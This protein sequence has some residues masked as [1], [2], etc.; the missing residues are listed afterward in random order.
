MRTIK[1][2]AFV[3]M[4]ASALAL[5]GCGG[6]GSSSSMVAPTATPTTPT[7]EPTTPPAPTSTAVMLPALPE[8]DMYLLDTADFPLEIAA[9]GMDTSGGVEFSCPAG[10]EDCTVTLDEDGMATSEGGAATAGLTKVA[11]D[12]LAMQKMAA[13]TEL[14]GRAAGLHEAL[15]RSGGANDVF[16]GGPSGNPVTV[17]P[18]RIP[19]AGWTAG[20]N[21]DVVITRGLTGDLM[22]TRDRAGWHGDAMAAA[23]AGATGWAGR[24]LS[25]GATQ[26][27]TVYS[28][29]A[30]AMRADFEADVASSIYRPGLST[31]QIAHLPG[32]STDGTLNVPGTTG[33]LGPAGLTLTAADVRDAAAQGL[34]DPRF[35]PAPG[36]TG[37]R[38]LTYT[39][40]A[41]ST[42]GPR[43][44]GA[45]FTGTFHGASGTYTCS[46]D[47]CTIAITPA[48]AA[49]P[50]TFVAN[51]GWTFLPDREANNR[52]D[53]QLHR[54]D[55][56]WLSFGWWLDEPAAA[57]PGGAF[58][59]N[60]QV[61]YGGADQFAAANLAAGQLPRLNLTYT[62]PAGGLYARTANAATGVT[63]ARGE[64]TADASLTA[65]Y[66]VATV[67]ADVSGTID[68]FTNGD[69]VDMSG[70]TLNLQRTA[71]ASGTSGATGG[72]VTSGDAANRA[73]NWEYTL[74][75][76]SRA[77]EYPS[78][79]A[80]RFF[81]AIDGN[82]AV[83]GG[84][85]AE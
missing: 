4:A 18:V 85:G 43:N 76:P 23:D 33:V 6:G 20:S 44:F 29:I 59:Y 8:G 30:N 9:G 66:G 31:G 32:A 42:P 40:S 22:V 53:A 52:N 1:H 16:T 27:I 47:P 7:P 57:R 48:N 49:G 45:S 21:S 67:G 73:G 71:F 2:L 84:F 37:S 61:F 51:N 80:G 60:A 11:A 83:A 81:A 78:G 25:N 55:S 39:Y 3:A 10:G 15:T 62:G 12:A 34:L 69:G 70:W 19:Q 72:S 68:G 65:R 64:F 28:N 35:F 13:M 24:V 75:G 17:T 26:S 74:Y 5:A 46:T 14:D 77:G 50:A 41:T 56:N 63:A 38:T 58:L 82:T 79:I 36:A 54:Q